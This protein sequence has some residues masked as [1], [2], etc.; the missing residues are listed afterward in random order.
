MSYYISDTMSICSDPY[1]L[2]DVGV[3]TLTVKCP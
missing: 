3:K 2:E 1:A